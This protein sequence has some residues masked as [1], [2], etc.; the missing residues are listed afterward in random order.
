MVTNALITFKKLLFS[1][2]DDAYNMHD[3]NNKSKTIQNTFNA[4]ITTPFS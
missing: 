1:P 3:P 4:A 2:V